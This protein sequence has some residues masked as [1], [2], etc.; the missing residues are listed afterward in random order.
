VCLAM[1]VSTGVPP[2]ILVVICSPVTRHLL[3]L[4]GILPH[5]KKT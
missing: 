3:E 1:T 5:P 2:L 4:F